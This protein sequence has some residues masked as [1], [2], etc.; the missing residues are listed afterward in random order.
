MYETELTTAYD[1]CKDIVKQYNENFPVIIFT[2]P[3]EKKKYLSALY[4][5]SRIGDDIADEGDEPTDIKMKRILSL[6]QDVVDCYE[7]RI[8]NLLFLALHDTIK[9][10]DIPIENFL[11]LL[12]AY[13]TDMTVKRYQTLP[14]LLNYCKDSACPTGR[15]VLN[16]F[17]M[18][19]TKLIEYA[20]KICIALQLVDFLQDIKSDA[21]IGRIYIPQQMLNK[22][23]L[24]YSDIEHNTYNAAFS[25]MMA[26]LCN[27][28]SDYFEQGKPLIA[29]THGNLKLFIKLSVNGGQEILNKIKNNNYNIYEKKI[30]LSKKDKFI[31]LMQTLFKYY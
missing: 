12:N 11:S 10:C 4:A 19:D 30:K 3:S 2:L 17:G 20:D 13:K 18:H 7:G 27:I 9:N 24:S 29:Q 25:D 23:G 22:Y 15:F 26:N 28:S 5:F 14:D 31:I 16:V 1:Y 21:H 8:K 6:E